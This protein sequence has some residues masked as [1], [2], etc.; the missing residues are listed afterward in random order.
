LEDAL[1]RRVF[2]VFRRLVTANEPGTP[3]S[4]FE[5]GE[6]LYDKYLLDLPKVLDIC[7]L[8][9]AGNSDAVATLI[10]GRA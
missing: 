1:A 10:Q 5:Q 3:L 4:P 2:I 7:V 9:G 6:L 8:F